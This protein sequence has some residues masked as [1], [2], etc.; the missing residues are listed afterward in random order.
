MTLKKKTVH[1]MTHRL[2]CG[3]GAAGPG[4][5]SVTQVR[6][7]AAV[8]I[9]RQIGDHSLDLG[10]QGFAGGGGRP[11]GSVH[12]RQV[13]SSS[14]ARFD[15]ATRAFADGLHRE[16]FVNESDRNRTFFGPAAT[17]SAS[18]RIS[19]SSVFLPSSLCSSR[20]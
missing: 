4:Q 13:A 7:D 11:M 16:S 18:F 17:S 14:R 5:R 2:A 1:F 6:L 9:G 20:T 19:A 10:D 12:P 15:R 8:S 3:S